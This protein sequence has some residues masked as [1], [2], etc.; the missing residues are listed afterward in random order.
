MRYFALASDY[1]GTLASHGRVDASTV[2]RLE[3]ARASGRRL[4]LVTGRQLDDLLRVFPE[5][6]L[7]DRVVA[8]NGAVLYDPAT[9]AQTALAE[10]PP[11]EFVAELKARAVSPLSV[12][13]V[14]VSTWEPNQIAVFQAIHDLALE[15]QV[16]F[17]KG[18]VMVL[19]TGTNKATGLRAA[20]DSLGISLHNTVGIGDAENDQA[21]LRA[22]EC[23]VAV[24]NALDSVKARVDWV[25]AADHG[26]GVVQLVDRLLESDLKDLASRLS[27]HELLLGHAAGSAEVRLPPFVG[28]VLVAGPS[29]SGKTTVT[30]SFL[31]RLA[32]HRYQF[33]LIDPEG[34][35]QETAGVVTLA[36]S[37]PGP[38]LDDVSEVLA[39]P[40]QSVAVSLTS[41]ALEERPRLFGA[42]L[43]RLQELRS[44]TGRPHWIVIDEAHHLMPSDWAPA[45]TALPGELANLLLV[46]VHPDHVAKA[47]LALVEVLIVVGRDASAT[48]AAFARGR[49]ESGW[50]VPDTLD[51]LPPGEAWLLTPDAE[52]LGFTVLRPDA[53]RQRHRRKYAEGQL[54]PDKSFYFRGPDAR[55]NL[56]AHNLQLFTQLAGG[57]DDETWLH[58]LRRQD[59]SRWFRDSIKDEALA[60]DVAAIERQKDLSPA[61][62]RERVRAAIEERY[63]AA[64]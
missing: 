42:L 47:A 13:R 49:G 8:E 20:L 18:A 6:A 10:P 23:G 2:R 46:T 56:R 44:G 26:A 32:A 57:V 39:P 53:D 64:P 45:P 28:G 29:G 1:D 52:P 27:R 19:P 15:L 60:S 54:G 61:E 11:A 43:P 31:E 5:T 48:A 30:T 59:Y 36:S 51:D 55:L 4:V 14:I 35:Y 12:G 40:E 3:Q 34:D 62:S 17:N 38:L 50:H 58:H 41:I 16:V 21:F 25:T 9:R 24:S 33:C 63:T 37:D 22:C 7:F